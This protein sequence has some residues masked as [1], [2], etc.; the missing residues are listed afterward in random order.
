MPASAL[1]RQLHAAWR[2][3]EFLVQEFD[4][5]DDLPI[6][7]RTLYPTNVDALTE[8]NG[9]GN[10]TFDESSMAPRYLRSLSSSGKR[11][12]SRHGSMVHWNLLTACPLCAMSCRYEIRRL[13]TLRTTDH[14]FAPADPWPS[15][16]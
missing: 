10:Y 13:P 4:F 7:R 8:T 2:V 11:M 14:L 6:A 1:Q 9:N 3:Y 15:P 16:P 5:N 12:C